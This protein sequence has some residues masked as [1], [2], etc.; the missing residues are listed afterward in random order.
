[1]AITVLDFVGHFR[2]F[3]I[4]DF[5]VEMLKASYHTFCSDGKW[6]SELNCCVLYSELLSSK[7]NV[8]V[9]VVA[10]VINAY[11][12]IVRELKQMGPLGRVILDGRTVFKMELREMLGT[13]GLD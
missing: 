7:F 12:I 5:C 10:D 2:L 13:V 9:I 3:F 8:F 11:K 4:L 6:I 1:M